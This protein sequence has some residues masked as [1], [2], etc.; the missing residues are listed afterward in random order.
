VGSFRRVY[1]QKQVFVVSSL[2]KLLMKSDQTG[3]V[4]GKQDSEVYGEYCSEH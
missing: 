1:E 4:D 3:T 2:K